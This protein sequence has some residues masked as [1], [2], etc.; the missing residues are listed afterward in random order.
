MEHPASLANIN[1]TVRKKT[2]FIPVNLITQ[3]KQTNSWKD[4]NCQSLPKKKAVT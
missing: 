3:M 1:M 2:N 4:T